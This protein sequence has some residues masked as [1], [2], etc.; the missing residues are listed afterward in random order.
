M[1]PFSS[2]IS[3]GVRVTCSCIAICL[4]VAAR[5]VASLFFCS[6]EYWGNAVTEL[7][8]EL[9]SLTSSPLK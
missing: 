5:K 9:S 2:L 7:G 3:S 8:I 1:L 6:S 4:S